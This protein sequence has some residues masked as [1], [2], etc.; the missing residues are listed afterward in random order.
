[1]ARKKCRSRGFTLIELLVVIAIIG[2]LAALAAIALG[3]ARAKARDARRVSDIRQIQTAL[4]MYFLDVGTY[5]ATPTPT[6]IEYTCLS[7]GGGWSSTCSGT[8]YMARAPSNPTP[9]ADGSCPNTTYTYNAGTNQT[10]YQIRYCLGAAT[11]GLAAGSHW[12]TPAGL[13]DD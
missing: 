6:V 3:S 11:G 12:A 13:A 2:I 4:E 9:R 1:M 5:P 7:S 10:T 8:T